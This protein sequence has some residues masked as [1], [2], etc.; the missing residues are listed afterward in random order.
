MKKESFK[1]SILDKEIAEE[2]AK[3]YNL[4]LQFLA[5]NEPISKEKMEELIEG[6]D[7]ILLGLFFKD[8]LI[9][10]CILSLD[11]KNN[12]GNIG[13]VIHPDWQGKGL[14]KDY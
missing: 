1:I 4:S 7:N 12:L 9:D 8:Q 5:R 2:A 10:H 13:I 3:I 11:E 6:E 14:G